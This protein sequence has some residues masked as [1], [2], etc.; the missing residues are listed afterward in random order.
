MVITVSTEK[1]IT[2]AGMESAL[3]QGLSQ[4]L[5]AEAKRRG[6]KP[7]TWSPKAVKS[8]L[9]WEIAGHAGRAEYEDPVS[10]VEAYAVAFGGSEPAVHPHEKYPSV[11][12]TFTVDGVQVT[13]WCPIGEWI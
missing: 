6:M 13:V 3:G 4:Y 5:N 10:L 9:V 1:K 2:R 8:G 7:L 12:T 11:E